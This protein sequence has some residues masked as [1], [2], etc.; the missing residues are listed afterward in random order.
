MQRLT[1]R[2]QL[3]LLGNGQW[4][5]K[6]LDSSQKLT[7]GGPYSVRAYPSGEAAGDEGY[8]FSVEGQYALPLSWPGNWRL[9][10]FYDHGHVSINRDPWT[11]ANNSRTLRGIG[12]GLLVTDAAGWVARLSLAWKRGEAPQTDSDRSPRL[13]LQV[14]RVF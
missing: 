3:Q 12:A 13:W 7:L 4:A 5:S 6:N 8:F 10:A 14:K 11:P 2:V 1:D 9:T